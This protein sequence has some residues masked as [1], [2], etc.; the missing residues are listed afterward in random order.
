MGKK[1]SKDLRKQAQNI[2]IVVT[3]EDEIEEPKFVSYNIAFLGG[4]A[5]SVPSEQ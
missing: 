3:P 5:K 4:E 2:Q 1:S